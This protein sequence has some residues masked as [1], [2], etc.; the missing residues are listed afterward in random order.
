M[1]AKRLA[2]A[3]LLSASAMPWAWAADAA[4][5]KDIDLHRMGWL[6]SDVYDVGDGESDEDDAEQK[7]DR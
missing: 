7:N 1:F 4:S 2:I 3:A 5:A 6:P